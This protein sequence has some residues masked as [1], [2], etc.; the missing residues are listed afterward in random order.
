[1]QKEYLEDAK[2]YMYTREG[3]ESLKPSE[4]EEVAD[5]MVAGITGGAWAVMDNFGTGSLMDRDNPY[6]TEYMNSDLWNPDRHDF[7]IRT[8][9][10]PYIDIFGRLQRGSKKGGINLEGKEVGGIE[11]R[12]QPPSH[13]MTVAAAWFANSRAG[14]ILQEALDGFPWGKFII[15]TK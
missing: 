10:G 12:P 5:A 11:I 2:S 14:E 8:R 9:V 1:M 4:I 13:A 6:L 15:A 3:A 7:A